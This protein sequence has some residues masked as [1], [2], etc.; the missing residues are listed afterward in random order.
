VASYAI[1][2]DFAT[3]RRHDDFRGGENEVLKPLRRLRARAWSSRAGRPT[4]RA[5]VEA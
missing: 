4:G 1:G 5:V 3:P 2:A